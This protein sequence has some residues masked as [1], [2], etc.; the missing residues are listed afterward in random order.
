MIA[1]AAALLGALLTAVLGG[2]YSAR[3]TANVSQTSIGI[4]QNQWA[5][6][7]GQLEVARD[8]ALGELEGI[9]AQLGGLEARLGDLGSEAGQDPRVSELEAAL[10]DLRAQIERTGSV[11]EAL[12]VDDVAAALVANHLDALR[13]PQGEAGPIGPQGPVGPQGSRG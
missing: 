12:S 10:E 13:G 7:I 11:G 3:D 4:E 2:W 1:L 5:H 9:K 6:K 8:D